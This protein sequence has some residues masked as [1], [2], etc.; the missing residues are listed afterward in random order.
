MRNF[1]FRYKSY[2][3]FLVTNGIGV[4]RKNF[5]FDI[6]SHLNFFPLFVFKFLNIV[7]LD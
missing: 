1:D 3:Q 2:K 6:F 4:A 5:I 7:C